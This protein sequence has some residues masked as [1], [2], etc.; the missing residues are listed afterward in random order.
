MTWTPSSFLAL[1]DF[2]KRISDLTQDPSDQQMTT[3]Y[4]NILSDN[5]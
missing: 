1:D 5:K 4:V 2:L 3:T